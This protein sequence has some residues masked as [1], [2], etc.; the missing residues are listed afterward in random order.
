MPGQPAGLVNENAAN[1]QEG[2]LMLDKA[3]IGI[4]QWLPRTGLPALYQE[5]KV[6]VG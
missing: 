1:P 3:V 2:K 5:E 6:P 4:P